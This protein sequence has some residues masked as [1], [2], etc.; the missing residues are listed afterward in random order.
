MFNRYRYSSTSLNPKLQPYYDALKSVISD[1]QYHAA[2]VKFVDGGYRKGT[3]V[4]PTF[5][6]I[7]KPMRDVNPYATDYHFKW[8]PTI[9]DVSTDTTIVFSGLL[10]IDRVEKYLENEKKTVEMEI[11]DARTGRDWVPDDTYTNKVHKVDYIR[12][13]KKYAEDKIKFAISKSKDAFIKAAG[14]VNLPKFSKL[15]NIQIEKYGDKYQC[16][17]SISK[18]AALQALATKEMIAEFDFAPYY[19]ALKDVMANTQYKSL[20]FTE[21]SGGK[22]K[23]ITTNEKPDAGIQLKNVITD[24]HFAFSGFLQISPIQQY[25]DLEKEIKEKHTKDIVRG[26]KVKY[27]Y[28][29]QSKA[30]KIIQKAVLDAYIDFN[31]SA[32]K[33]NLPKFWD[34]INIEI[35][36]VP[37]KN[38]HQITISLDKEKALK[39]LATS[40]L[41]SS[42]RSRLASRFDM[43]KSMFKPHRTFTK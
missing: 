40:R 29:G 16:K 33:V 35:I 5:G 11:E 34:M 22:L 21:I 38:S 25:I 20:T 27:T 15:F 36:P 42:T 7:G 13:G 2:I 4:Q 43:E 6:Y 30:L 12:P 18:E 17:V 39:V 32:H 41:A 37:T 26:L 23:G 10:M 28:P 3:W 19:K 8:R 14:E 31:T 24:T 9:E 1:T